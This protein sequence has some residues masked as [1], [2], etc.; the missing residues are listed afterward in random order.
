MRLCF[1]A[2]Q[3]P[4]TIKSYFAREVDLALRI[5]FVSWW[6]ASGE[7]KTDA[8]RLIAQNSSACLVL[9]EVWAPIKTIYCRFWSLWKLLRFLG[10]FSHKIRPFLAKLDCFLVFSDQIR[11]IFVGKTD[12]I[13]LVNAQDYMVAAKHLQ[14][15]QMFPSDFHSVCEHNQPLRREREE[16]RERQLCT[17]V[18]KVR[19]EPPTQTSTVQERHDS[20]TA[21]RQTGWETLDSERLSCL[22]NLRHSGAVR[23]ISKISLLGVY[24]SIFTLFLC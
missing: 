10:S 8:E 19:A 17:N 16:E 1:S 3:K 5:N 9:A 12:Q 2:A 4:L 23:R 21:R 20:E 13:W 7:I 24:F 14:H 15:L 11:H 6:N 18:L 22:K